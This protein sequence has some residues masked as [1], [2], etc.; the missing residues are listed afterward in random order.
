MKREAR[1]PAL[2]CERVPWRRV[3]RSR[4]PGSG[5]DRAAHRRRR[6]PPRPRRRAC[7]RVPTSLAASPL[8]DELLRSV[9]GCQHD[10]RERTSLSHCR[11]V[12]SRCAPRFR[13][14]GFT[15]ERPTGWSETEVS[16]RT[17]GWR[18]TSRPPISFR[19]DVQPAKRS[20]T[21]VTSR[22]SNHTRRGPVQ[23]GGCSKHR[24][25][26]PH[27]PRYAG[28]TSFARA[29]SA[30]STRVIPPHRRDGER[31]A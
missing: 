2:S 14:S 17:G 16:R 15:H 11:G 27:P 3:I 4:R 9:D 18:S 28:R 8:S 25:R 24:R 20:V 5:R 26:M 31:L 21:G 23:P 22:L 10:L 30:L 6:G 19:V 1:P 13:G 12:V 29:L 7:E